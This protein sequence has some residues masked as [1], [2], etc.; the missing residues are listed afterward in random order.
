MEPIQFQ[1]KAS[2]PPSDVPDG[3]YTAVLSAVNSEQVT[4]QYGQKQMWRWT[5]LLDVNG[6][7]KELS[8]FTG[9]TL[10]PERSKAYKWVTALLNRAPSLGETLSPPIG[11]RALVT[12]GRNPKGYAKIVSLAPFSEPEQVLP[13]VPR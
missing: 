12:V 3:T 4:S 2:V 8:A 1:V 11:N 6:E 5:F 10:D 7:A 9:Q 13:G